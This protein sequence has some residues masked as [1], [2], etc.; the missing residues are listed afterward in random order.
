MCVLFTPGADPSAYPNSQP[1]ECTPYDKKG[2]DIEKHIHLRYLRY[3]RS[4]SYNGVRHHPSERY[5]VA[6]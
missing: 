5:L 1:E 6:D 4:N 3:E 2:D